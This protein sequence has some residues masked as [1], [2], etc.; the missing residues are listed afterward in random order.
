MS[1]EAIIIISAVGLVVLCV[2]IRFVIS[3]AVN[4]GAQSIENAVARNKN[5]TNGPEIV[6]L[7]DLYPQLA[8]QILAKNGGVASVPVVPKS[9]DKVTCPSCGKQASGKFCRYCGSPLVH[10]PVQPQITPVSSDL[11]TFVP[12]ASQPMPENR[13]P[14]SGIVV[15]IIMM[16]A[17]VIG[18]FVTVTNIRP[19]IDRVGEL[20]KSMQIHT[21]ETD[22]YWYS[23]DKIDH[24]MLVG[25]YAIMIAAAVGYILM[26]AARK[27][28]F[29]LIV[30]F[31]SAITLIIYVVC[32]NQYLG[33]DKFMLLLGLGLLCLTCVATVLYLVIDKLHVGLIMLLLAFAAS[34]LIYIALHIKEM[35]PMMYL[36]TAGNALLMLLLSIANKRRKRFR[37][38][39]QPATQD[40][41]T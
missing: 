2:I 16:I 22:P 40:N 7:R 3:A 18:I 34:A 31:V 38:Y 20:E 15:Y 39:M 13:K 24:D 10:Q 23:L 11:D 12:S 8:A 26:C 29:A 36:H 28:I 6:A 25:S 30:P 1:P 33:S 32:N 4:K 14:G 19:T 41:N 35:D 9:D 21:Y 37:E 5:A 27:R 17:A